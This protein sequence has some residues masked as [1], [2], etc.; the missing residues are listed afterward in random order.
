MAIWERYLGEASGG[1]LGGIREIQNM[2]VAHIR[3]K[4]CGP[5]TA[6]CGLCPGPLGPRPMCQGS[7]VSISVFSKQHGLEQHHDVV[8]CHHAN[9]YVVFL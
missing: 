9:I 4:T 8:K 6:H 7:V 2:S 1:H 5:L 3:V